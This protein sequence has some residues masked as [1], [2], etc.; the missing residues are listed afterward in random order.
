MVIDHWSSYPI[1]IHGYFNK[2]GIQWR[3]DEYR[4]IKKEEKM[5]TIIFIEMKLYKMQRYLNLKYWME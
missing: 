3:L 5:T 1:K 4:L 2:N